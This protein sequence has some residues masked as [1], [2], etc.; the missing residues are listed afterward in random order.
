MTP[1]YSTDRVP[2]IYVFTN[3]KNGKMYI[4]QSKNVYQRYYGH[5][6]NTSGNGMVFGSAVAKYG[7]ES[8]DWKVL[9]RIPNATTN[10]LNTREQ[11]WILS[12]RTNE[13]EYGYNRTLPLNCPIKKQIARDNVKKRKYKDPEFRFKCS[14]DSE[15][16]LRMSQR[17][18]GIRRTEKE[19]AHLKVINSGNRNPFYGKTH[20]RTSVDKG[21]HSRMLQR[22]FSPT[23]IHNTVYIYFIFQGVS[24]IL[25]ITEVAQTF[26]IDRKTIHKQCKTKTTYRN[27]GFR[28]AS[29]E[30]VQNYCEKQRLINMASIFGTLTFW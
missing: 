10:D 4:G 1:V 22:F 20:T 21:N 14:H 26:N 25:T 16:R 15:T 27:I 28:Y 18:K 23:P 8:F 5:Q 13:K 2:G 6:G 9:E 19:K 7:F 12:H 30:E 24:Q 11:Y 17:K 3:T 29:K